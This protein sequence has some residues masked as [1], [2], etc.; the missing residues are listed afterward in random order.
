[1]HVE[2]QKNQKA[3]AIFIAV[4]NTGIHTPP[5]AANQRITGLNDCPDPV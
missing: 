4:E 5:T 3:Q 1:L 2:K